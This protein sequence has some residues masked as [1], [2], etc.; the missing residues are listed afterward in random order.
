MNKRGPRHLQTIYVFLQRLD[1]LRVVPIGDI[2]A[3]GASP[4]DDIKL[5]AVEV[6]PD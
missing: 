5:V 2:D 4:G 1:R 3:F 6:G